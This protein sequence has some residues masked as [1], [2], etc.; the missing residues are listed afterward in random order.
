[1]TFWITFLAVAFL[2]LGFII[3]AI[4][5]SFDQAAERRAKDS[6]GWGISVFWNSVIPAVIL[7]QFPQTEPFAPWVA[8]VIAAAFLYASRGWKEIKE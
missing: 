5:D 3:P 7:A 6:A 1:M 2:V 4:E 8:L